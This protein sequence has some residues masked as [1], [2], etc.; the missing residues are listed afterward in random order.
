MIVHLHSKIS[1]NIVFNSKTSVI[2]MQCYN[3]GNFPESLYYFTQFLILNSK[4]D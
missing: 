1:F 4:V 3:D 2:R